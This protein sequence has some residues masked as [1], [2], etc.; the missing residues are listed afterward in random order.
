MPVRRCTLIGYRACGKTTVGK[1]LA[2]RLNW[3]YIDADEYLERA[4][5]RTIAEIFK[6]DGEAAFRELESKCLAEILSGDHDTVIS[7]GGGCVIRCRVCSPSANRGIARRRRTCCKRI[8]PSKSWSQPWRK[9]YEVENFGEKNG[10]WNS[11]QSGQW[12]RAGR[13]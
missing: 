2:K 1:A 9:C 6:T 10:R 4:A 11:G 8:S 3:A 5:K 13:A 7:T 12:R